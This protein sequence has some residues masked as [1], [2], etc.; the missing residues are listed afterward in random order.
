MTN[1]CFTQAVYSQLQDL[2][3]EGLTLNK[4]LLFPL[5]RHG[6][7]I[8]SRV[9]CERRQFYVDFPKAEIH[10]AGFPCVSWS[11]IGKK[12]KDEGGDFVH[13]AAWVAWRRE[14]QDSLLESQMFE[15]LSSESSCNLS[16]TCHC[17]TSF[18]VT[19]SYVVYYTSNQNK[20]QVFQ[21]Y[22]F[23]YSILLLHILAI[24]LQ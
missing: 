5:I 6:G 1:H 18:F 21:V 3:K 9:Y 17:F 20:I 12:Q 23:L 22:N 4:E 11:P 15:S 19:E 13:W 24:G 2:R 10:V 8:R 7:S 16:L 14:A